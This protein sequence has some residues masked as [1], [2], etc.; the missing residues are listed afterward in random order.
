M[1]SKLFSKRQKTESLPEMQTGNYRMVSEED[2]L[3][4]LCRLS[5][6][7]RLLLGRET[8]HVILLS[9]LTRFSSRLE[10]KL[11]REIVWRFEI[12]SVG[13][14]FYAH[15]GGAQQLFGTLQTQVLL[16]GGW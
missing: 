1:L 11:R 14:F 10:F 16:V 12:E 15:I 2:D 9:K 4:C 6:R 3:D 13:Y 5:G 7:Y 8:I